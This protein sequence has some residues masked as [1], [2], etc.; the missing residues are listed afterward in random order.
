VGVG[1]AAHAGQQHRELVAAEA[2]ECAFP[3]EPGDGIGASQRLLEP[4]RDAGQELVTG[5]VAQTIVDDLEA[6][7][8]EK[9][10]G[11]LE[12]TRG[13]ASRDQAPEALHEQHP[14][15]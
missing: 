2:R 10:D 8:V 1:G 4:S 11:E 15:G 5:A 3:G 13:A 6:I 7:D 14:V 12:G 9:E